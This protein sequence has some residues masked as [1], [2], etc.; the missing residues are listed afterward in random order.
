MDMI[1][2]NFNRHHNF[3]TP[4]E[5]KDI[6]ECEKWYKD[7]GEEWHAY[8]DDSHYDV[9]LRA[10][11]DTGWKRYRI[12]CGLTG[13][14]LVGEMQED[15]KI[16]WQV[17]DVD[18]VGA[19][20]VRRNGTKKANEGTNWSM[21]YKKSL[22]RDPRRDEYANALISACQGHWDEIKKLQEIRR[23]YH[24]VRQDLCICDA[25]YDEVKTIGVNKGK[26]AVQNMSLPNL[27]YARK[28]IEILN[29][30]VIRLPYVQYTRDY[31]MTEIEAKCIKTRS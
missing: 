6:E 7:K 4:N 18:T 11:S 21:H 29:N 23:H 12:F 26:E 9:H 24:R 15:E 25:Y 17:Y 31:N 10:M 28:S 27:S 20:I 1:T 14:Q 22:Y 13:W 30:E 8:C 3:F 2:D 19:F 5:T 16:W